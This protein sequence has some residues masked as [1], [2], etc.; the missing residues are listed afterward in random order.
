MDI[1]LI[2]MG[3]ILVGMTV[4]DTSLIFYKR[5]HAVCRWPF[6]VRQYLKFYGVIFV[7]GII[8]LTAGNYYG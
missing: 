2:I 5:Y 7:V 1:L 6:N 8:F 3:S 4:V